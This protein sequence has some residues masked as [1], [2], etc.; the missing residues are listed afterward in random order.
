MLLAVVIFLVGSAIQCGAQNIP[1]LFAGRAIAGLSIG[2]L[3]QIVP[4]F[5]SEVFPSA[6]T[7]NLVEDA[8]CLTMDRFPCLKSEEVSSCFSNVCPLLLFPSL[9]WDIF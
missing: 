6:L 4:L 3:T 2:Q 1:M 8:V 5:I 9:R 7:S